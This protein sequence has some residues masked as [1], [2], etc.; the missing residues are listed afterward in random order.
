LLWE[1]DDIEQSKEYDVEEVISS[2]KCGQGN[3]Q[4]ILNLV[5]W[6][7]YPECKDW[8]EEPFDNFSVDGLEK[9]WEFH[10]RNRDAPR[11]YR[12]TED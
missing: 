11:D 3:N 4:R 5:K 6:R 10:R 8:M 1:A 2:A 7:N 12:L 9:L